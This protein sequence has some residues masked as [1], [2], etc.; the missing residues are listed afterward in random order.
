[1]LKVPIP[2]GD[3]AGSNVPTFEECMDAAFAAETIPDYVCDKCMSQQ[4]ARMTTR[5]SKLPNILLLTFKRFTNAGAKIRGQINWDINNMCLRPWMA[6]TRCPFSDKPI[7]TAFRT[8]AVIEHTGSS[9]G[10]HYRMFAKEN[11]WYECDD[12]TVRAVS[13]ERVVSPD[14]YVIFAVPQ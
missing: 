9:R 3:K 10:G 7:N 14:S 1:M 2:G 13:A 8:F 12:E 6:F 5:I 11:Q 4:T